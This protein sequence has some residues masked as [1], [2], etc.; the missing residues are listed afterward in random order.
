V[1]FA[2]ISAIYVVDLISIFSNKIFIK[3]TAILFGY[4]PA[5]QLPKLGINNHFIIRLG[6]TAPDKQ[7]ENENQ[8][9]L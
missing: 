6:T 7:Y 1:G 3:W 2:P 9:C 4:Q 8:N 5:M